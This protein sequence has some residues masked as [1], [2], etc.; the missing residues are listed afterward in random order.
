MPVYTH[1]LFW[2]HSLPDF[3]LRI[4]SSQVV[5]SWKLANTWSTFYGDNL[6]NFILGIGSFQ[7]VWS[8]N[9]L[10]LSYTWSILHDNIHRIFPTLL[11]KLTDFFSF[12]CGL[13]PRLG[14][15]PHVSCTL[16]SILHTSIHSA[17]SRVRVGHPKLH[18]CTYHHVA[19]T[20]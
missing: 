7:W 6:S 18:L 5:Q 2:A 16:V 4:G 12:G 8:C 17:R 1:H 9:I 3:I 13:R 14:G 19:P 10:Q 15:T 11:K 20:G